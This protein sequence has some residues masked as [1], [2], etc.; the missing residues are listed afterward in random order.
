[1]FF[2][3]AQTEQIRSGALRLLSE[4]GVKVPRVDIRDR[5]RKKGFEVFGDFVKITNER[6]AMQ[7]SRMS[8]SDGKRAPASAFGCTTSAYAHMYESPDG[9]LSPMTNQMNTLLAQFTTKAS[10]IWPMLRPAAPG[11]PVD[12][13]IPPHAQF[14]FH[15]INT[16]INCPDGEVPEPM[17]SG[18]APFYFELAQQIGKPF[19]SLP[20]YIAS[21]MT[22]AGESVDIILD[23][24]EKIGLKHANVACMP[25]VGANAPLNLIAAYTQSVAETLGGAVV[26][27]EITGVR[28]SFSPT[29]FNMDFRAMTMA[30]GT[31]EKFILE[32][33]NC[34][35]HAKLA[36]C[37]TVIGATDIH[38]MPVKAGV[39][40]LCEKAALASAGAAL[41]SRFF[42]TVGTLGMDEVYSPVQMLMDLDMLECVRKMVAGLP[43]E[44]YTG[45]IVDDVKNALGKG[46]IG[47]DYTLDKMNEFV[48]YP[49]FMTRKS[50]N[51]QIKEYAEA[52]F[53]GKSG[54]MMFE[55]ARQAAFELMNKPSVWR[56]DDVMCN[57]LYQTAENAFGKKTV[58]KICKTNT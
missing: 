38:V 41:G 17:W 28:T 7:F 8:R 39:Q 31:P 44:K 11:H 30:F 19:E 4:L 49:K 32:L 50:M 10:K 25:C 18:I 40:A 2:D 22:I 43:V 34:E 12:A 36:G 15:A 37:D 1:M 14:F 13:D 20:A 42:H 23:F 33:M 55:M 52:A 48:F 26:I 51:A 16:F 5:L 56:L 24:A 3:D 9:I 45:D 58:E 53:S 46:Y 21:P 47:E 29:L 57:K 35:I 54:D 6:A 27:E